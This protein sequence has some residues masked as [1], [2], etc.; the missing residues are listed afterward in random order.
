MNYI[1]STAIVQSGAIIGKNV[2]IGPYCIIG[3]NVKIGN[4]VILESHVIIN[5]YT[6]ISD[7]NHIFPFA[8]IGHKPQ[9]LGYKGELTKLIIGNN[10]EIREYVTINPG[11]INGGGL[12]C[13]GN[14]CLFMIGSHIGHDCKIGNFVTLANQATL[15]GHV[16]L[17]DYVILGGLSAVRQR[18]RIGT[19]A[20]VGGMSGVE[21]DVIPIGAV[22]GNRAYLSGLNLIGLKRRAYSRI[23]IH[24]LRAAYKSIFKCNKNTLQSRVKKI[25]TDSTNQPLVKIVLDFILKY[26]NRRFCMPKK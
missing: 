19:G 12:T 11:T 1:H 3:S 6:E 20:I 22:I 18:T 23:H 5:G 14:N 26:N 15:A 24:Q 16:K 13:I 8:S 7:N 9:D 2:Q 10:N 4:N 17:D 25:L 21:F